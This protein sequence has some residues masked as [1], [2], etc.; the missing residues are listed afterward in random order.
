MKKLSPILLFGLLA[1]LFACTG[2][3]EETAE[4]E[5]VPVVQEPVSSSEQS[6]E[7]LNNH[8]AAFMA[9]DLE[10]VMV[11]YSDNSVVITPDSTYNGLEQIKGLFSS[12]FPAFPT[13]GTTIELD[14]MVIENEVAY[15]IW[16]GSSPSVDVP[17]A[18]D[19][20][21]IEDG[22]IQRQTFAGIIN[23]KE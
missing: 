16:H 15:I 11:D 13:E 22:K 21:I 20:F 6:E 4:V 18:T 23:P 17:F 19:T 14:K 8:L 5:E 12:L 2:P 1:L 7:V 9:N 3:V 10:A